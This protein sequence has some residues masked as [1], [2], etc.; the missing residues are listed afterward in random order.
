MSYIRFTVD[1]TPFAMWKD[2]SNTPTKEVVEK[3][4]DM[5]NDQTV[6]RL[7]FWDAVSGQMV[8]INFGNV[9]HVVFEND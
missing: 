4:T 9:K 1:G 8:W 7:S 6:A 2:S 5:L 3:L